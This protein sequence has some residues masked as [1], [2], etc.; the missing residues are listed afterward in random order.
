[1]LKKTLLSLSLIFS[2]LL[3]YDLNLKIG[4]DTSSNEKLNALIKAFPKN[5]RVNPDV[6]KDKLKS[7]V[8]LA[9]KFLSQNTLSSSDIK[10][11]EYFVEKYLGNKY[12]Q[13]LR[14]EFVE[15]SLEIVK[16]Y[17]NA[18]SERFKRDKAYNFY[19]TKFQ[20]LEEAKSF[21]D[22]LKRQKEQIDL[23]DIDFYFYRDLELKNLNELYRVNL[24]SQKPFEPSNV[25]DR[26]DWYEVIFY[27]SFSEAKN[28]SFEEAKPIIENYLFNMKKSEILEAKK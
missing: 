7:D 12:E 4:V 16:S 3:S 9:D 17:Y 10:E 21:I 23:K 13:K 28:L 2:S 20:K 18:N 25:I 11:I 15:N 22:K 8:T 6:L 27:I 5:I 26:L 14:D 24:S 1:M 19:I